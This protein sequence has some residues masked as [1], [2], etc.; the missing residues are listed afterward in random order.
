MSFAE[1]TGAA[2][3]IVHLS[4]KEALDR[5]HRRAPTRRARERRNVDPISHARQNLRREAENGGREI[6]HVAA[7]ARQKRN[8]PVLWNGLR[9]GLVQTVAT[10]HCPFDFKTQ[11]EMG[12]NDFT[13]IPNGIPSLED[14]INV[15]YTYGVKTGKIDL[16]TFVNCA[17]TQAAKTFDLF[18]RKGTIQ[19]GADADLVVFDPGLSRQNFREDASHQRGL[20]RV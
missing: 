1:L 14:R 9:D 18:P 20:Q 12:K 6:C 3:Y 10:D 13:K 11:K 15:L 5:G 16:H 4:C 17:S 8:Q 2:T 7:A 19:P